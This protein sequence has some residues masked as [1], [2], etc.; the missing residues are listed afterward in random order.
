MTK[1]DEEIIIIEILDEEEDTQSTDKDAKG[2]R[3]DVKSAA[4][5]ASQGV[6]QAAQQAWDS[7]ARK[8]VTGGVKKGVAKGTTAVAAKSAQ[9][10]HEHMV[11]AAEEQ[12]KQQ[13][14]NL[15]TKV[16]ETDWRAEAGKGAAAGLRWAS[17]QVGKL[18]SRL[19]ASPE[20]EAPS[21]REDAAQK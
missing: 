9:F 17:A 7:D 2:R 16:R 14:A 1:Q 5:R 18:A 11:K 10:L 13:A 20:T 19:A 8:T 12:A 3:L 6:G 4:A 15:Q 21:S